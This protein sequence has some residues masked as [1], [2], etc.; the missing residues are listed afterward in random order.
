MGTHIKSRHPVRTHPMTTHPSTVPP[1][2]HQEPLFSTFAPF[3]IEAKTEFIMNFL[4]SVANNFQ[5]LQ[6]YFVSFQQGP[7][8]KTLKLVS[9][10]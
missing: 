1:V 4:L 10:Y 7:N 9:H 3:C 6:S 5:L 8:A 2:S